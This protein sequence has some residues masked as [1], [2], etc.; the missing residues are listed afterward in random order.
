LTDHTDNPRPR[1]W[2]GD[3]L[4]DPADSGE[5]WLNSDGGCESASGLIA[6]NRDGVLRFVPDSAYAESFGREWTWFDTTQLDRPGEG[7]TESR[8]T[9][10]RK[11]GWGPAD[12]EGKVVLD[13]GCG[14]GRFAEVASSW[15]ARVVGV[16]LSDAVM[17]AHKNLGGRSNVAIVQADVFNLPFKD[18]SFDL[19]YSLGVL[20][21]TPSTQGAFN[22]LPEL[23]RPGGEIA[24]WV[25]SGEK[26]VHY[27]LSD[28]YRR[29]TW[30]MDH[31]RLLRLCRRLEPL[32][33][34]YRTRLGRVLW[35]L[36]PVSTHPVREWRILDTFDWYAPR[37]QWK[38]TWAEVEGWF[39]E[40]GLSD[41]RRNAFPVAIAG[42]RR[43]IGAA[44]EQS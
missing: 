25:Y 28:L 22:R 18:E 7:Q 13:V 9:F 30:K 2:F 43:P 41:V 34:L 3:L 24:I 11:T 40:A 39:R 14:M 37:Y 33:R 5:A 21:H 23:L 12:L 44:L 31:E 19:I 16:D 10:A 17:A 38:H 42:R 32:G 20:H 15:G 36:L 4:C 8:E 26:P 29:H 1:D 27:F 6:Q 35:P